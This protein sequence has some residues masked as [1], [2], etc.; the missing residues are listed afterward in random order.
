[1]VRHI[2]IL[3]LFIGLCALINAQEDMTLVKLKNGKNIKG[4]IL[5]GGNPDDYYVRIKKWNQKIL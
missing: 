2:K 1:M 5:Q 3:L 4:V